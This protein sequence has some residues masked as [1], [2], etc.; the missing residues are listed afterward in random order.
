MEQIIDGLKLML[1]GMGTVFIFL[2]VMIGWIVLAAKV[3]ARYEHLLPEEPVQAAVKPPAPDGGA[4]E[5][6]QENENIIVAISTAVH[7]YRSERR[8]K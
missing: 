3:T 1:A 7:R 4:A 6:E 2:I 5:I 8:K